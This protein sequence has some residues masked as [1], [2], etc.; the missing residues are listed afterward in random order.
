MAT[1]NLVPRNSGEGGVGRLD[2]AWATGVFDNLYFGGLLVSMDQNVRTSDD[3]EFNSGNFASGLTLGGVDVSKLGTS[4][5]QTVSGAA[6]FLF[7]SNVSDN[8]GV[9]NKTFYETVNPDLYLSGV[10]VA[11]AENLRVELTWDGPN[12]DYMGEAFVNGQQI[13]LSNIEELGQHTRRFKGFL[14]NFN[15]EGLNFITGEAN[16][17]KTLISINELG[18]G[19]EAINLS[20][21]SIENAT[22]KAGEL[23]GSTHL[24]QGDQI[25]IYADFNT[26]DVSSIKILNSGLSQGV[27]F[28]NYSLVNHG[29]FYRATIPTIVSN[30]VGP[31]G[32]AVQAINSFGSTGNA[33]RSDSFSNNSGTRDLDQTYPNISASD[34]ASYNGRADGLRENENTSFYNNVTNW[35]SATD[36][37][38]YENL[39]NDISISNVNTFEQNKTV[40]YS[41]G[42][43]NDSDNIKIYAYRTGNGATDEDFVKVKIANGPV[44]TGTELSRQASSATSPSQIG[45]SEVK[46][47]DVVNS[48]VFIDGNGVS[49]NNVSISVLSQGLSNGSQTSYSSSYSKSTLPDGSF[50]FIVPINVYGALGN[51]SRDGEQAVTFKAKNNFNT[52]S[53]PVITTDTAEINNGTIP[54]ISINSISYPASQQAIKSSESTSISN[55][56]TNFDSIIYSSPNN[57]LTIS[58]TSIYEQNKNADYLAGGYNVEGDGGVNN[59]K[60]SATKSSNG[61]TTES[62]KIVNIANTPLTLSINNLASSLSSS[63]AGISDQFYMSSSQLM[64]SSPTL[65][66]DPSQT[67]P[68]NLSQNSS[69]T[70]KTSNSYTITVSDLDTKGT[71]NWQVSATNLANIATTSIS[72][73]PTYTL[74]GF[75]SRTVSASPNSLGAGLAAIG[76]TV[77]NVNS[78]TFENVSEGGTAPNG[79]T[80]YTYQSYS[81]GIQLDNSYDLNNKFTVCNSSGLTDS[82]GGYVFNL[83]KL[84][85][86]ANTSTLNPASFVISE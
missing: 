26:S 9:T 40:S 71:F 19:P 70:G 60:I 20:I 46:A 10:T 7:F 41:G 25:N 51:S 75:S 85:R 63:P 17:R 43:Y 64:L 47:G 33:I 61:A 73:N 68:S 13:P 79:G 42:I 50:E 37:I 4:I 66:T 2:K 57:Q 23:L 83:D 3:V 8:N 58:N 56:V 21:D 53:D 59:F 74:A 69:G 12:D 78:I 36:F 81:D 11:S 86:S 14:D 27:D 67:S 54:V 38:E 76:T 62:L 32:V 48:K 44:I 31:Q 72:T 65:L 30:R 77:S 22:P 28:S 39:S 55:N 16:D 15:A 49:I 34:P 45:T 80:I 24:K 29:G 1:R 84:N 52:I 18:A 82:D 35:N 6:E 5:Q